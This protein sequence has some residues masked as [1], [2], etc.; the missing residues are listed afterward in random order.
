MPS[1]T[2]GAG[3]KNVQF[4]DIARISAIL[5]ILVFCS[6]DQA[7]ALDP[8]R[9]ISQY[10]HT[11]WRVQDGYFGAQPITI[12]QTTDGYIWV[13]TEA[14]LFRFDGV[15]F[16]PWNA[17]SGEQ[18]P[19]SI[20]FSLLAARDG[21]LWIGTSSGLV[22]WV[23][24]RLI[25]Y[26]KGKQIDAI[27]QNKKN[28]IWMVIHARAGENTSPLCRVIDLGIHCYGSNDGVPLSGATSLA[29]DTS[30]NLWVGGVTTLL[31]WR[32]ESS[33]AFRTKVPRSDIA[34]GG[35]AS[36]AA[37]ADGSL[38]VGM[39]ETSHR[40]GLQHLVDGVLKPF[41]VPK[42]NGETLPGG[43]LLIDRQN[44]LWVGT[45]N[46]GIYKIS[47]SSV[48][49]YSSNSGL[50]DD[51]VN[52]FFEDREGNL[53]VATSKGIDMFHDLRV[54]SISRSEGLSEGSVESVLAS[55]DGSVW[56]GS[57]HLDVLGPNGV[58]P[59]P[60]KALPGHQ[61]SS[62]LEDHAGHLWVGMDNTL[63]IYQQGKFTQIKRADGSPLGMVMGLTEDSEHNVWVESY[64][65]PSSL[66]RIQDLKIRDEFPV[67]STPLASK[68][69]PDPQSGIWLGLLNG[70]L[71]RFRS[72]KAEI[73][74][75]SG[76]PDSRVVA[77]TASSDG[78]ILGATEFGVVGWKAGKQ[79]ILNV[80]NGLPCDGI[81]ALI[82]D[83][84]AN[85]WLFAKCGLIEIEKNELQRWWEQPEIKLK[86]RIFDVLDG[87]RPGLGHFNTS[88]KTPDGRLW[89]ANGSV[90]QVVDPAHIPVNPLAPP[91][92]I[93]TLIADRKTYSLES[94]IR[95]P[96]LTRDLEIDYTALSFTLPQKVL[97][98]YMLEGRDTTWQEPGTRRQAFYGDLGP[99]RYRFH[100]IACNNDG[101]WNETGAS[102]ILHILP[103]YYQT[104][105]FR[106]VCAVSFLVLLGAVYQFRVKQLHRQ[107][108][109]D[110]QARVGERTRIARDLHDTLLQS[111]HGLMFQFQAARNMLPRRAEEAMRSLDE[112]ISDTKRALAES[113][114]AIQGLRSEPI[115][116]GNLAEL[117]TAASQELGHGG[118][119]DREPPKFDLIE[120]GERRT[121]S[122]T[123]QEEVGR[124]AVELLRNAYQHAQAHRIEAEVR[125]GDDTLRLR[126]RDNGMGIDPTVLKQGGS[127]GHWGL[128]GI[129]ERAERIGA[130]VDFWSEADA[131]TEVQ[132]TVPAF[133]AYETPKDSLVSRLFG[134]N[135]AR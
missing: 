51:Y 69:A 12:S 61:V 39:G 106:I 99:G 119:G 113:R 1:R 16:V 114:D 26:L 84:Q 8:A 57:N 67:P 122:L 65:P 5:A 121:L 94:E 59:E 23:N 43:L 89:I 33:K 44:N 76:H 32:P 101:V 134:R 66:I 111:L 15:R 92:A 79:Q 74:S 110:L 72:G 56:I 116:T 105:W 46:E 75:F 63:S 71:A 80:G 34:L 64:G 78:S 48:D 97:F 91:V 27:L 109:A 107:F 83:N 49:R 58:S 18:L 13:G 45:D 133:I 77:L 11:V 118:N 24:Q 129:R 28:E 47:G 21:S 35:V 70:D 2:T 87:V 124:I 10:G 40:G 3:R 55:R 52:D 4:T 14:G 88:T 98:R 131:G 128:R 37:A 29:E 41:V 42:S 120:E 135:R 73:F 9:R 123:A 125:Y 108:A 86:S 31:R 25:A 117:L 60:G 53:W 19:S 132:M 85:L 17:I 127:A 96:A 103:A 62:L 20:I 102:I 68:L 54:N 38:W 30:G 93:S 22:H 130:K 95:L 50:S 6:I 7:A 115:A 126:I 81:T 90:V 104:T 112:S 100:V 82:A 36:L